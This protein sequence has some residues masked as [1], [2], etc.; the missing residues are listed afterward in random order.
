MG[1]RVLLRTLPFFAFFFF[2]MGVRVL[3]AQELKISALPTQRNGR[4]KKSSL[5]I[6]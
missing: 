2:A 4:L 3:T 6:T 1:V 5:A